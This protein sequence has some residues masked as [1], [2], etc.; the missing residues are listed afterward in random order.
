MGNWL[1][2]EP[3]LGD[4][5]W[6]IPPTKLGRRWSISRFQRPSTF[7][8]SPPPALSG[9]SVQEVGYPGVQLCS[10]RISSAG[11]RGL[12]QDLMCGTLRIGE[13]AMSL[14][15]E[16]IVCRARF[17]IGWEQEPLWS[18]HVKLSETGCDRFGIPMVGLDWKKTDRDRT[19][20]RPLP[21][22]EFL[23]AKIMVV[24]GSPM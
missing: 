14:A 21:S 20:R 10:R 18:T 22:N 17:I 12:L 4:I 24:S 11:T 7:S 5:G 1:T 8:A 13:W 16:H 23:T 15:A 2:R 19:R 3:H 9:G 6:N